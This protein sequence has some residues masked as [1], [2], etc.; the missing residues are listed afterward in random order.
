MHDS[1]L[2]T[3][4]H[5]YL[6]LSFEPGIGPILANRLLRRFPDPI[7]LY[8]A[9]PEILSTIVPK[10]RALQLARPTPPDLR[11]A[12]ETA[13]QWSA[14]DGRALLTPDLTAYPA[15][16]RHTEDAPVVLYAHGNL[17]RPS[18]QAIAI[19]GTR[20]PTADG[21]DHAHSFARSLAKR[22][23]CVVSGLASGIDAAAHRGALAAGPSA[24]STIAVLGTGIDII[25]PSA[26]RALAAQIVAEGGLLLSEFA[27]GT[28]PI[29]A[30]FPRR[31][32]LVAGLAR[33][34]LVIEAALRSGSLITAR[35]AV[36]LGR[37]VFALPSSIHSPLS[38]GP[39]SLIQQ[40]AKLVTCADDILQE[41]GAWQQIPLI[42]P[43]RPQHHIQTPSSPI[44]SA[45]GYDPITEDTLQR[46][47]TMHAA[48]LHEALLDLELAGRIQ[49]H[50]DGRLSRKHDQAS[51]ES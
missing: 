32:R 28:G 8:C 25:Y 12:I 50:P 51:P 43:I 27:L 5:A 46:R 29:A 40:G 9:A 26:H 48:A 31:N 4:R 1:A 11:A 24:A 42:D 18:T 35:L 33:G 30:N 15:A 44:W 21:L 34:T 38:R 49:R 47:T 2:P 16:L 17:E 36:D 6:R 41:L 39:H 7:T 14:G 20:N 45:I 10:I 23:W 19:V 13:L 3:Q 37:E 22:E